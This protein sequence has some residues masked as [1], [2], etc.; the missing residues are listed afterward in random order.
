MPEGQNLQV[1]PLQ[2]NE[3][4]GEPYLRLPSPHANII[5]TPPRL[6]DGPSAV[7]ILNDPRIYQWLSGPP[8]PYLKE[9]ADAWFPVI[10]SKA[11]A[12]WNELE[13]AS[14]ESPN[15]PPKVVSA[16]PFRTI[17]EQKEDGTDIFL[18]DCELARYNFIETKDDEERAR[19]VAE[20]D[21]RKIGDPE[22][23]WQ[24][25][26]YLKASHHKKGIM[27]AVVGTLLRA[28]CIPRV[29][30]RHIR[31]PVFEDNYGS[32]RVFEKNGFVP[33]KVVEEAL[34]VSAKGEFPAK[35]PT[36]CFLELKVEE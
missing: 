28:W 1:H 18:G 6:S 10:K 4:T 35:K 16:C 26:D 7:E 2:I 36:L 20:N 33:Y 9:H 31:L 14:K 19:Q 12:V 30:V 24:L 15:E 13:E 27:T 23:I 5:I 22:I 25:G 3:Q 8:W 21:A 32:G 29:G 17:R 11:D 34:E